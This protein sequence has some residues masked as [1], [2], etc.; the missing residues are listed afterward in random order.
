MGLV[1]KPSLKD[2]WSLKIIYKNIVAKYIMS[3]NRFELIL[4]FWHFSDNEQAP[5]NYRIFKV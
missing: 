5:E 4:R 1:Q 2:Y 3:R